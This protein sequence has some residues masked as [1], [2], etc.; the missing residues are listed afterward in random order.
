[1]RLLNRSVLR[2]SS[3]KQIWRKFSTKMDVEKKI[4]IVGGGPAG[5]YSA[6]YLANHLPNCKVDILE[7]FP[8]PYGLVRYGVAPDHPEVKNVINTF[9]K[10]GA[11]EI[12]LV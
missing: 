2:I 1:M 10:T 6:Q 8:V 12:S 5:F 11:N 9:K 3:D 4:C 7:K